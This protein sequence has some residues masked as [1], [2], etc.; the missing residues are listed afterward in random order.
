[1]KIAKKRTIGQQILR[2]KL[3]ILISFLVIGLC[4]GFYPMVS[5]EFNQIT[6]E[7]KTQQTS[8]RK[9]KFRDGLPE[10]AYIIKDL[11]KDW[12]I[13]RFEEK[14]YLGKYFQ[15]YNNCDTVILERMQ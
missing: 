3:L 14:E 2:F 1:M 5:S 6:E 10:G 4:I 11:G 7:N 13:V 15:T 9:N 8:I 12:Y